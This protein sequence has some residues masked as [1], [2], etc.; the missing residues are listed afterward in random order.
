[1]NWRSE[2]RRATTK[3]PY[4]S[5]GLISPEGWYFKVRQGAHAW[6]IR[7]IGVNEA[8]LEKLGWVFVWSFESMFYKTGQRPT[9]YFRW[10]SDHKLTEA[11]KSMMADW[12]IARKVTMERAC[13]EVALRLMKEE[14]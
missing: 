1:M 12:C 11:Q 14:E 5:D 10:S 9:P 7:R 4:S 6:W 3:S 2:V 13:G 8:Y